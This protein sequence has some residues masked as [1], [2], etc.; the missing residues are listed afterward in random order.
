MILISRYRPDLNYT[1]L[2]Y[3]KLQ[4]ILISQYRPPLG[5]MCMEAPAG[6]VGA[7]ED[8]KDTAFRELLEETGLRAQVCVR[9]CALTCVLICVPL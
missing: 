6:L 4:V 3:T 8:F 1:T 2:H 9:M 7:G 5:S